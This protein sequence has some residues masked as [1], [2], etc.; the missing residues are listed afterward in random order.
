MSAHV[1]FRVNGEGYAVPVEQVL[2]VAEL[3]ELATVPGASPAVLGVRN[4]RGQVLPVVD[5][6]AVLGVERSGRPRRLVIAE[7]QGR[8]A[9]LAVD[10]VTDVGALAGGMHESDSEYLVG[11]M[12]ADGDVVRLVD[13]GR[14][15]SAVQVGAIG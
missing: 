12:P 15:F 9:G 2:Q 7:Y 8:R 14:V 11:T 5:F 13:L 4:F 3:S 10:D 1:K 6:A